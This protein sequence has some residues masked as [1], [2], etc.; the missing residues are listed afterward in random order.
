MFDTFVTV[1]PHVLS[2]GDLVFGGNQPIVFD[3]PAIRER[4]ARPEVREHFERAGVDILALLEPYLAREPRVIG[5]DHDRSQLQDINTDLFPKDEYGV[6][7][8]SPA[9]RR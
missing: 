7:R 1:F 6:P 8:G 9:A 3:A 4:L 5:P 2:Y